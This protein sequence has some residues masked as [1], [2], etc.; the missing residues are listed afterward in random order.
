MFEPDYND[1]IKNA[2]QNQI[3]QIATLDV[4]RTQAEQDALAKARKQRRLEARV[5]HNYATKVTKTV[6]DHSKVYITQAVRNRQKQKLDYAYSKKKEYESYEHFQ[7]LRELRILKKTD[8]KL[9]KKKKK[10]KKFKKMERAKACSIIL[11]EE[12]SEQILFPKDTD[13][14]IWNEPIKKFVKKD[15]RS[16]YDLVMRD[17]I[18]HYFRISAEMRIRNNAV[19]KLEPSCVPC[20]NVVDA[21]I[22]EEEQEAMFEVTAMERERAAREAWRSFYKN[23]V[24]ANLLHQWRELVNYFSILQT[25]RVF[26]VKAI[27]TGKLLVKWISGNFTWKHYYNRVMLELNS[28]SEQILDWIE[29]RRTVVPCSCYYNRVSDEE[30]IGFEEAVEMNT[31]EYW[32]NCFQLFVLP[33]MQRSRL[34]ILRM[35]NILRLRQYYYFYGKILVR[36]VSRN[37]TW[38]RYFNRCLYEL[39]CKVKLIP[40]SGVS[41]IVNMIKSNVGGD[42]E[43][44]IDYG[45]HFSLFDEFEEQEVPVPKFTPDFSEDD[46]FSDVTDSLFDELESPIPEGM[47][48]YANLAANAFVWLSQDKIHKLN[49]L[50]KATLLIQSLYNLVQ[51][52]VPRSFNIGRYITAFTENGLLRMMQT[53][54]YLWTLYHEFNV[55]RGGSSLRPVSGDGFSDILKQFTHSQLYVYGKEFI[56]Q[57]S[58]FF[59]T[60]HIDDSGIL[61]KIKEYLKPI[62]LFSGTTSLILGFI[63]LLKT[64][65]D[66]G[67]CWWTTGDW[68]SFFAA[69]SAT[70]WASTADEAVKTATLLANE[71]CS[72]VDYQKQLEI[73]DM[74]IKR[75]REMRLTKHIKEREF[76]VIRS[77]EK[78][79]EDARKL[80]STSRVATQVR[81]QPFVM[82]I[83]GPSNVGKSAVTHAIVNSLLAL[84][85][86]TKDRDMS[87][88]NFANCADPW[89]STA[90]VGHVGCVLEEVGSVKA[91]YKQTLEEMKIMQ[92]CNIAPNTA[93]KA[94]LD[95]KGNVWIKYRWL[96]MNTNSLTVYANEV[97]HNPEA[98]WRRLE[99][100]VHVSLHK[101]VRTDMENKTSDKS[102]TL[103]KTKLGD[104]DLFNHQIFRV[105]RRVIF[106]GQIQFVN[107]MPELC[108]IEDQDH[109]WM[110]TKSF[111]YCLKELYRVHNTQQDNSTKHF[112]EYYD[113]QVCLECKSI[114]CLCDFERPNVV[115]TAY[116]TQHTFALV[117][118]WKFT[119]W[120]TII[121]F[122]INCMHYWHPSYHRDALREWLLSYEANMYARITE[123]VLKSVAAL[124]KRAGMILAAGAAMFVA[125]KTY[126]YF[127]PE[128]TPTLAVKFNELQYNVPEGSGKP[129][130]YPISEIKQYVNRVVKVTDGFSPASKITTAEKLLEVVKRATYYL[131]MTVRGASDSQTATAIHFKDRYLLMNRHSFVVDNEIDYSDRIVSMKSANR[132]MKV[133][134]ICKAD[135]RELVG[136][137]VV[138]HVSSL[139]ISVTDLTPYFA[140]AT[141]EKSYNCENN[142]IVAPS[143]VEVS[144]GV[145]YNFNVIPINKL[146]A[147]REDVCGRLVEGV[148]F[149]C[150]TSNFVTGNSGSAV[151]SLKDVKIIGLLCAGFVND[152]RVSFKAGIFQP[153]VKISDELLDEINP[154]PTV[155]PTSLNVPIEYFTSGKSIADHFIGPE[156]PG[157]YLGSLVGYSH[158]KPSTNIRKSLIFDKVAAFLEEIPQIPILK[159]R[160]LE[161]ENGKFVYIDPFNVSCGI[162]ST[163]EGID[164]PSYLI[165]AAFNDYVSVIEDIPVVESKRGGILTA[166]QALNGAY[167]FNSMNKKSAAGIPLGGKQK[168]YLDQLEDGSYLLK[169]GV[170]KA[171]EAYTF[172][173][174]NRGVGRP[175]MSAN[176]KDEVKGLEKIMMGLERMFNGS[177]FFFTLF[178]RQYLMPIIQ[179]IMDHP[180]EMEHAIGINCMDPDQWRDLRNRMTKYPFC[181]DGDFQKFDLRHI[182]LVLLYFINLCVVIATKYLDYSNEDIRIVVQILTDMIYYV[183]CV[184]GDL[185][186]FTQGFCSGA[187]ITV[188]IN[189]FV[190]SMYI[191]MVWYW[192]GFAV[193]YGLFRKSNSL[194]TYGDDNENSTLI[195][196]FNFNVVKETLALFGIGYTP[197]DKSSNTR[198]FLPIE[199]ISFLKRKFVEAEVNGEIV[200]LCPLEIKSILKSLLYVKCPSAEEKAQLAKNIVDAQKQFW[201][202]GND[203]FEEWKSRFKQWAVEIDLNLADEDEENVHLKWYRY[204]ELAEQYLNKSMTIAFA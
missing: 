130:L 60:M 96:I 63:K 83:Y 84:D 143:H 77:I 44:E 189:S 123:T 118:A 168:D 154:I 13:F 67:Y 171:Y 201:Y 166:T 2:R 33:H 152:S 8:E 100:I 41:G 75:A 116:Y 80:L 29:S 5:I 146:K 173:Y 150:E 93:V 155:Q 85:G 139:R 204:S 195:R 4:K 196:E 27:T 147:A 188:I 3:I 23:A 125:L 165:N 122:F 24:M 62:L 170:D 140:Y 57:V 54:H 175:I 132:S 26:R 56:T 111:L 88:V 50:Q 192:R 15:W 68:R 46:K 131:E 73:L 48:G 31:R 87:L 199:E 110:D 81:R 39:R 191:R 161:A 40:C 202:H 148:K 138:V 28:R 37:Y 59:A 107:V 36:N 55:W 89:D 135:I 179:W 98:F 198:D 38:K 169:T 160:T 16:C 22:V 197:S 76:S 141:G 185:F 120:V 25:W 58:I 12:P 162:L 34:K 102:F 115:P 20:H 66:G 144:E 103:D 176:I 1:G 45:Q 9:Y 145:N 72:D 129:Y 7:Q 52:D 157:I 51:A 163:M 79:L 174:V 74:L 137:L 92:W 86:Y 6:T 35:G 10:I 95:G 119:F 117:G 105:Q 49:G 65:V 90:K 194:S 167:P 94:E 78:N 149:E 43:H 112:R 187:I 128:V 184:K 164:P 30:P 106:N 177:P 101:D 158:T 172:D 126:R 97:L 186:E 42:P 156:C 203:L 127:K 21:T 91:Q 14:S 153:L 121:Y 181:F 136:D 17:F 113:K 32:R 134:M 11:N 109:K 53:K 159:P 193:K 190:S 133:C 70:V 99:F 142:V 183:V 64:V 178:S 108:T 69:D 124:K 151:L 71:P 61:N 182:R 82:Q 200:V 18:K 47:A 180:V 19:V 104:R 114:V